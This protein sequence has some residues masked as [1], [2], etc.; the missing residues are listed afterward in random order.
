M[1]HL[2]TLLASAVAAL[3]LAIVAP[4]FMGAVPA[5]ADGPHMNPPVSHPTMVNSVVRGN[6]I[7]QQANVNV[8]GNNNVVNVRQQVNVRNFNNFNNPCCFNRNFNNFNNFSNFN[9]FCCFNRFPVVQQVP[10]VEPIIVPVVTTP[11]PTF[12]W[13]N[14]GPGWNYGMSYN[15]VQQVCGQYNNAMTYSST[16][17]NQFVAGVCI[18]ISVNGNQVTI[19][20]Y[21]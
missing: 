13:Q 20:V 9:N 10:V 21:P 4:L 18:S 5:F 17:Y 2:R 19:Q 15:Q 16:A 14:Y 8:M 3:A 11:A 1:S 6:G 12:F 7:N